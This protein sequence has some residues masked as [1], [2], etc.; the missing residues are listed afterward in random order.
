MGN[1]LLQTKSRRL[2]FAYNTQVIILEKYSI[3]RVM[4]GRLIEC[5]FTATQ[6]DSKLLILLVAVVFQVCS[7]IDKYL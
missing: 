5:H 2:Y 6:Q 7:F 4:T 3:L 1:V